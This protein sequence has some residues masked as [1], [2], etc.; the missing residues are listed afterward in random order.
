MSNAEDALQEKVALVIF[1]HPFSKIKVSVGIVMFVEIMATSPV[2][3]E[4]F[5]TIPQKAH[6]Q[7]VQSDAEKA[8]SG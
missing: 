7:G 6:N 8:G 5:G 1:M 2:G 4:Q 3:K